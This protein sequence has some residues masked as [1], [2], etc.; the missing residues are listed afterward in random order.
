MST[1]SSILK[2]NLKQ[3]FQYRTAAFSGIMTQLFF[4][5][6]QIALYTAFLV[7]GESDFT[8]VQMASY[9]WLQQAFYTLFKF[10][11]SQK[12]EITKEKRPDLLKKD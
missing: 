5:F 1:F 12:L 9:I 11:D 4:G 2:M 8:I 7:Q 3:Q 6:M 10:F